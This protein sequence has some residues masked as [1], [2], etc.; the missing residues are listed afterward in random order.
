[1]K[2]FISA[3]LGYD[4]EEKTLEGGILGVVKAYYGCVEAQGRGTLHCHMLVW[5]EGGLNPNEI[6]KR[7]L[8]DPEFGKRLLAFLNDTISVDPDL[9]LTVPSDDHHPCS[10]RGMPVDPES[11][12]PQR[13]KDLRNVVLQ[14]QTHTHSKTCFKYWK[15]PPEPKTCHLDLHEDN[16]PGE[17]YVDPETG[18]IHLRCLDGLVN[19][20]NATMLEAIRNNMDIKFIGSG[21]SAKG[22]LY[23]ITDYIIKSELKTHVAFAMLE[24]AVKKL[25]EY[26]PLEDDIMIRALQATST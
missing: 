14:C 10:V 21:A 8:E 17:S 16:F 24:L 6:K 4:P 19:N 2:A 13:Q 11:F 26:N 5:L 9:N 15:R 3:L 1:M 12:S 25:G 20:F 23:C 18:E 22:I 7:V